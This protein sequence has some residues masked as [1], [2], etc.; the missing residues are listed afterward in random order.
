[1]SNAAES[2]PPPP[3]EPPMEIH[4]SKPIHNWREFLKEYVIIVL[5]VATALA[6]EQAVEAAHNHE[7]AGQA[8]TTI[9]AEIARNI[10]L[11]DRRTET[12]SCVS[13]RLNEVEGL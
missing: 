7:R 5:G 13:R 2:S 3:E 12:E 6:A 8:R 4:K 9:R 1:M 11:I 10:A